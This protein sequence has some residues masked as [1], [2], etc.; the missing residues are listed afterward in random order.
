MQ[1]LYLMSVFIHLLAATLWVGG[2][3]FLVLVVVPYLRRGD[4]AQAAMLLRE[5]GGRF[6]RVS[7]V[8]FLLIALTGSYN[9]WWRGVRFASL[10]DP[11]F[12]RSP[13]G[14]AL[15]IKLLLFALVLALSAYHDFVNGP[16]ATHAV[17]SDPH[18]AQSEQLRKRASMLGRLNALLALL[19]YGAAVVLVRGC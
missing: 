7:W 6:S 17:A 3:G 15:A 8:C 10:V 18:S 1:L 13:F 11:A 9:A 19:L 4:R 16:R 5:T 12:L 14:R 2:M